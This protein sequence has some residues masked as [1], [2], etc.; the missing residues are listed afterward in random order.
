MSNKLTIGESCNITT[1]KLDS[2]QAVAG[3]KYPFFTCATDPM[4]IDSYSFDDDVVLVA[5]NNAQGNFHVNRFKGKFDAYQRTYILTAKNNYNIDYIYYSLKL[6]LKRLKE[7]AQ[8]SQTKFLT[9]PILTS[10]L[11]HESNVKNQDKIAAVLSAL[12]AKIEVN[13]RINAELESLAKTIYD[14]WFVQFDF[15]NED[16]KPYKASGGEMVYHPE[17]KREIPAGWEVGNIADLFLVNPTESLSKGK[18]SEYLDMNALPTT[19]FMTSEVQYKEYG[20][21][22]KFRNG[23]VVIA[24]ITPCLENGKTALISLLNDNSIGFG[25]TEFIVLRGK[26]QSLSCFA[27]CLSRSK[28]FR[29][30]AISNMM[31]T[32]GRKRVDSKTIE[33]FNLIIPPQILLKEFESVL[34]KYFKI[35]TIHTK[36]NQE[37]TQLRDWLLPLLMNGQITVK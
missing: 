10:I 6:E 15:P 16:G 22:M 13:N 30:F 29:D 32:S 20:G 36:Q 28:T 19:G 3:G 31:G 33:K 14:Y 11:L 24:R 4:F 37:L 2:N 35:S 25:S 21:G 26:N 18:V 1:G 7:K 23:D 27:A 9:M 17:L 34:S 5:G 8:G 12:D